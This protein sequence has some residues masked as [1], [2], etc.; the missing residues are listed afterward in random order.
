MV[1][2]AE[3]GLPF[4]LD[5]VATVLKTGEQKDKRGKDLIRYF[6]VPCRPTKAKWRQKQKS[7]GA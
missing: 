6:C 5:G 3:L 7:A 1:Q 2:A 4:S